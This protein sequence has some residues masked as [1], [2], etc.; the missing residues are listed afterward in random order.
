MRDEGDKFAKTDSLLCEHT[1]NSIT[2]PVQTSYDKS[3]WQVDLE[4]LYGAAP[5]QPRLLLDFNPE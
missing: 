3:F 4:F 2:V 1:G 5:L